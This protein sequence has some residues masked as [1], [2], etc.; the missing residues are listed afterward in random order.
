DTGLA[1]T[2]GAARA[3]NPATDPPGIATTPGA[4]GVA[5][6]SGDTGAARTDGT[7]TGAT[8]VGTGNTLGS[9]GTTTVTTPPAPPL[10][11]AAPSTFSGSFSP[12]AP[13]NPPAV[14]SGVQPGSTATVG[15]G[16]FA[17][18]PTVGGVSVGGFTTPQV[19]APDLTLIH[20]S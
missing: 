16:A 18:P 2:A 5:T 8:P 20:I 10:P 15:P 12:T 13:A 7:T 19:S 4:T 1:T 6:T 9:P 14:V 11:S 17:T 3:T